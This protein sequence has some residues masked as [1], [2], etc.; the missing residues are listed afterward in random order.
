MYNFLCWRVGLWR[1]FFFFPGL[2]GCSVSFAPGGRRYIE[3]NMVFSTV[4]LGSRFERERVARAVW[5][6]SFNN[7]KKQHKITADF[8]Q[9][10]VRMNLR[11]PASGPCPRR[12]VR[13]SSG[14]HLP[15]LSRLLYT[16]Y[17]CCSK[18]LLLY[19]GFILHRCSYMSS[20][21]GQTI[22]CRPVVYLY[23]KAS[24]L[25]PATMTPMQDS[26]ALDGSKHV[27]ENV[28]KGVLY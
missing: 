1:L 26:K 21:E 13:I 15:A 9:R 20:K 24:R 7:N 2:V 16:Q 18:V 12:V 27:S 23:L 3:R 11:P 22:T 4:M 14:L 25:R 6:G 5:C 10:S 8:I 28:W 19:D 17:L